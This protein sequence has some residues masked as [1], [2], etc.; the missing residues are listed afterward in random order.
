MKYIKFSFIYVFYILPKSHSFT[1]KTHFKKGR[2]YIPPQNKVRVTDNES[3]K[4]G[5][6]LL[7]QTYS[8]WQSMSGCYSAWQ[9]MLLTI[10]GLNEAELAAVIP[11]LPDLGSAM[12][13][14]NLNE[15]TE[16]EFIDCPSHYQM[17]F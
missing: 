14:L 9:R 8:I 3:A 15:G 17:I 4:K 10:E 5:N 16:S 7:N 1:L 6:L 11:I 2:L 13:K 12:E